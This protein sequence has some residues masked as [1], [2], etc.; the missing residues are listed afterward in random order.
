MA[1]EG[2]CSCSLCPI[3]AACVYVHILTCLYTSNMSKRRLYH[4]VWSCTVGRYRCFAFQFTFL[5]LMG[6]ASVWTNQVYKQQNPH[7]TTVVLVQAKLMLNPRRHVNLIWFVESSRG[8]APYCTTIDGVGL[9]F[10]WPILY[11]CAQYCV[12]LS[13]ECVDLSMLFNPI[14]GCLTLK[15]EW[16]LHHSRVNQ[17]YLYSTEQWPLCPPARQEDV[18]V[19]TDQY[20]GIHCDSPS[21]FLFWSHL[22][23]C[24]HSCN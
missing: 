20:T 18:W 17:P 22:A 23:H 7:K 6:Q 14:Q 16:M 24:N 11:I 8:T 5:S 19:D 4:F 13:K 1:T 12:L 15:G 2:Y 21:G 10:L 9:I 3:K